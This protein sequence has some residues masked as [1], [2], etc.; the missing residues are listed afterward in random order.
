M[1]ESAF[2]VVYTKNS[3]ILDTSGQIQWD[4]GQK[5]ITKEEN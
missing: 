2:N 3:G 5:L 1:T 4:R